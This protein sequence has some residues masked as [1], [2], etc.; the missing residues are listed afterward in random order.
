MKK[1][2]ISPRRQTIVVIGA[3]VAGLEA[4]LK[5]SDKLKDL[6]L[7]R[8]ILIASKPYHSTP[9]SNFAALSSAG[10]SQILG[11]NLKKII[12]QRPV[13][14]IH[15]S[16]VTI[17]LI[18][19]KINLSKNELI[20]YDFLILDQELG[21][22]ISTIQNISDF[23]W[24]LNDLERTAQLRKQ[25]LSLIRKK[26]IP[27]IV[28]IGGGANAI[29]LTS[30]LATDQLLKNNIKID[31]IE[32]SSHILS[33]LPRKCSLAVERWLKARKVGLYCA[34]T[35]RKVDKSKIYLTSNRS[36]NYDI[37]IYGGDGRS[38]S[39]VKNSNFEIDSSG[40][41]KVLPTLQ[42]R[43][44]A[45]VYIVTNPTEYSYHSIQVEKGRLVANN[46]IAQ[47]T[48]RPLRNYHQKPSFF[49]IKLG[50]EYG[51]IGF[52]NWWFMGRIVILIDE[53]LKQW[54]LAGLTPIKR[55]FFTQ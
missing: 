53:I 45:R 22:E 13:E 42:A 2:S 38:N 43:G 14:V 36:I 52:R 16:V 47:I 34:Q 9:N 25:I 4:V 8:I 31:L 48:H 46:I 17:D 44:F 5:L 50:Y 23:G 3:G 28:V 15:D 37:L 21:H 7:Y 6:N 32:P 55:A 49:L 10:L 39:P 54:Y 35:V 30:N 26:Q 20:N 40:M 1:Y 41:P 33:E 19:Q 24:C 29:E 51:L 27:E 11:L 18:M 12:D